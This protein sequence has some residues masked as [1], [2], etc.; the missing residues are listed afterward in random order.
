MTIA[1]SRISRPDPS[2]TQRAAEASADPARLGEGLAVLQNLVGMIRLPQTEA[3]ERAALGVLARLAANED[4]P[5]GVEA[6]RATLLGQL[7]LLSAADVKDHLDWFDNRPLSPLA[8]ALGRLSA[9]ASRTCTRVEAWIALRFTRNGALRARSRLLFVLL[10]MI[11]ARVYRF[12]VLRALAE[13]HIVG[14]H[15]QL[16][17]LLGWLRV[18]LV[19]SSEVGLVQGYL[20]LTRDELYAQADH[21]RSFSDDFSVA[22]FMTGPWTRQLIGLEYRR[23]RWD[24]QHPGAA[25][26]PV[27]YA[28]QLEFALAR[29]HAFSALT[30]QGR[31]VAS[32]S[33]ARMGYRDAA[34]RPVRL[35]TRA[36]GL[37]VLMLASAVVLGA[38]AVQRIRAWDRQCA[39]VATQVMGQV[40]AGETR[41]S[42]PGGER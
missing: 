17:A 34:S 9:R 40:A 11:A 37:G 18:R 13:E 26:N 4:W 15:E 39:A 31:H 12:T 3:E 42:N 21:M 1:I 8:K 22:E 38:I 19:P 16:D 32:R 29:A 30:R 28:G 14:G 27:H 7:E 24:R 25:P 23:A 36:I 10:A 6:E 41:V 35:P 2:H 33:L 5:K 20:E